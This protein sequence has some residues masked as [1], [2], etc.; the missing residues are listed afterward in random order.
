MPIDIFL[1][2]I[3]AGLFF[4]AMLTV[5]AI[6]E[7]ALECLPNA[8]VI[9]IVDPQASRELQ[10]IAA[11]KSSKPHKR[12]AYDRQSRKAVLVESNKIADELKG[13]EFMSIDIR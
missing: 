9:D 10:R 12:F 5:S 3:F 13:E 2:L 1:G 6:V 7:A 4:L 8:D 11:Q